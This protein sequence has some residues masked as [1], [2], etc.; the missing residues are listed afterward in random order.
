[1]N[2]IV[3][4]GFIALVSMV[5]MAVGYGS[6]GK[7]GNVGSG[8]TGH[9]SA[10]Y[11]GNYGYGNVGTFF[12]GSGVSEGSQYGVFGILIYCKVLFFSIFFFLFSYFFFF[13]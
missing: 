10:Y 2:S 7:V 4:L 9:P 3:S 12:G 5:G 11:G 13:F 8:Y 6:V 1:M